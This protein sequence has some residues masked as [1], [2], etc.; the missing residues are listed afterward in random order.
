MD[1]YAFKVVAC[2]RKRV[3]IDTDAKNEA[4]D[5]FA[6]IHALLTPAFDVRGIIATHFGHDRVKDSMQASYDE[7]MRVL[8]YSGFEGKVKAVKGAPTMLRKEGEGFFSPIKPVDSEGVRTIIDEAMKTP[9]GEYL[10]LGV[11][12]PLTN[13]ASALMI[14][15]RIERKIIVVWNGG[16]IYPDGGPE[17]NLVNDIIAA[18]CLMKSKVE[19]WQVPTRVYG[20]PR[21][22]LAEMQYKV[23][24]CGAIGDYLFRQTL[25]FFEEMQSHPVWPKPESLDICDLTVIGLLMEDHR[26]CYSYIPA[27]HITDEMYYINSSET[28]PIRV[29]T[30]IDA[31]YILE[32]FFC[33]LAINYR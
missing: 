24:P 32:D 16:S 31:R 25:E 6:I 2:K 29:Y 33:K 22:G 10:Y 18:N 4:D 20:M 21:V 11:L 23:Q 9:D 17:F 15:P 30:D 28:R 13:V 5:Q 3:L 27:P 12:G 14:E 1:K 8:H 7:M 19:L 26:Y